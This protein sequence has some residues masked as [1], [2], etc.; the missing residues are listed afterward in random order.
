[1]I[2]REELARVLARRFA[3]ADPDIVIIIDRDRLWALLLE[4][5]DEAIKLFEASL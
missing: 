3:G 1:V 5:A 4:T 2:H